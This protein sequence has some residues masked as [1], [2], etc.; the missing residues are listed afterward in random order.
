MKHKTE[1]KMNNLKKWTT[2]NPIK[3]GNGIMSHDHK[4]FK[5]QVW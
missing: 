1:K 4:T 2:I 5:K 3:A